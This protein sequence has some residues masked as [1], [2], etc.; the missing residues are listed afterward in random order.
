[1]IYPINGSNAKKHLLPLVERGIPSCDSVNRLAVEHFEHVSRC[2][3]KNIAR[4]LHEHVEVRDRLDT[5]ITELRHQQRIS[6]IARNLLR[7]AGD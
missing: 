6:D 3:N 7:A 5:R 1:M 4:D 2:A